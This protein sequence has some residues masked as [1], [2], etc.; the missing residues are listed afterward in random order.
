MELEINFSISIFNLRNKPLVYS[1]ITCMLVDVN[2][3]PVWT[4]AGR[5]GDDVYDKYEQ[6]LNGCGMGSG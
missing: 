4:L 5:R 1:S 3:D 2:G 6:V